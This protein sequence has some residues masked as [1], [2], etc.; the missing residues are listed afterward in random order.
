MFSYKRHC[1]FDFKT[2]LSSKSI[3]SFDQ[4][5]VELL[6]KHWPYGLK[7]LNTL[8]K[9]L[10]LI[11]FNSENQRY[12]TCS[13][14]WTRMIVLFQRRCYSWRKCL[15][16]VSWSCWSRLSSYLIS[17]IKMR[18]W[19]LSRAVCT[20]ALKLWMQLRAWQPSLC[21]RKCN[22]GQRQGAVLSEWKSR[23]SFEKEISLEPKEY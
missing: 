4:S 12:F 1:H 6:R 18:V 13:F 3:L 20:R 15:S 9:S 7:H 21:V 2:N 11:M 16:Q 10:Y 5:K 14:L 23:D 17:P 22:Q 8:W 19:R